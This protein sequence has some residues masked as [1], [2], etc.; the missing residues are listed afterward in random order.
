[1]HNLE[2]MAESERNHDVVLTTKKCLNYS[3][4]LAP[5]KSLYNLLADATTFLTGIRLNQYSNGLIALNRKAI[6]HILLFPNPELR[7]RNIP[8]M[9]GFKFKNLDIS[10]NLDKPEQIRLK[11]SL[12]RGIKLITYSSESPLRIATLLSAIGALISM[13]YSFIV[14]LLWAFGE[15]ITPGWTSI[16]MQSSIMYFLFSVVLLILSEYILGISRKSNTEPSCF[17]SDEFTSA[18][19]HSK[20]KLNVEFET[21][22]QDNPARHSKLN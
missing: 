21:T 15:N 6:N 22:G 2:L 18:V 9:A 16:S 1:M 14:L 7:F 4:S 13:I 12:S 8:S 10:Y 5:K 3:K 20:K 11:E 19:M 17:I